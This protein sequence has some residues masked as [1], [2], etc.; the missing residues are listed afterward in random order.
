PEGIEIEFL[1]LVRHVDLLAECARVHH[2]QVDIETDLLE[3]GGDP[4]TKVTLV[5]NATL[6]G[7][8]IATGRL[9]D[10]TELVI[11]NAIKGPAMI[12]IGTAPHPAR[13]I[14]ETAE[15]L[16]SRPPAAHAEA[17]GAMS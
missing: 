11:D 4:D 15:T 14:D 9:A 7:Q 6:P 5:E 10:L 16:S 2:L 13:K 17:L 8:K 12:F 1:I 3:H